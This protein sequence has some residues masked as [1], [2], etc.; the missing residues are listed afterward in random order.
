MNKVS[1]EITGWLLRVF[2][3]AAFVAAMHSCRGNRSA[4][5]VNEPAEVVTVSSNLDEAFRSM[6]A[7]YGKWERVRIPVSVKLTSPKN[8]SLS[9]TATFVRGKSIQFSMRVLGMEV[10]T[11]FVTPDSVIAI[12][13]FHKYYVAESLRS[14]LDGFPVSIDNVSDLLTGRAFILGQ[15]SLSASD[16]SKVKLSSDPARRGW[17]MTPPQV[18]SSGDYSFSFSPYNILQTLKIALD[19]SNA[20][21]DYAGVESTAYGPMAAGVILSAHSGRL[22]VEATIEWNLKRARW[23]GEVEERPVSI[24]RGYTRV[25][26]SDLSKLI[27]NM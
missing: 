21:V 15:N 6:T 4:V 2:V 11:L 14:F 12:E 20:T 10:A 17:T 26:S 1:R 25:K 3:V 9:G 19:G 24:P 7:E 5:N 8:F 27:K 13:K 16:V 23:D 18:S 22:A